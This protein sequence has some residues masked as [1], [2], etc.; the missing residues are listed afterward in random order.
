MQVFRTI[1]VP[2]VAW[3]EYSAQHKPASKT[4]PVSKLNAKQKAI[5]EYL[6]TRIEPVN[7]AT[8]ANDVALNYD[9]THDSVRILR[10][11][12][13]LSVEYRKAAC[14]DGVMRN[15]AVYSV[16]REAI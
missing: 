16:N 9:A 6:K 14:R 3:P 8:I 5:F 15:T 4:T 13:L 2:G 10:E 7:L 12:C 1:L 11:K